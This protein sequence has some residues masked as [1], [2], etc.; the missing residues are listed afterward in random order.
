LRYPNKH[1]AFGR[2]GVH[3]CL[4]APLARMEAQIAITALLQRFPDINLAVTPDSLRRRP[5]LF[6]RG[7]ERLPVEF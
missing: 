3:H 5:G 2:G 7:L 1:L 4:G 6:L